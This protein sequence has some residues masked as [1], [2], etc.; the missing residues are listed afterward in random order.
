MHT[1][2]ERSTLLCTHT[3]RS[4]FLCTHTERSVLLCTMLLNDPI[5]FVSG[6]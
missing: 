4:V 1:A 6:I 5:T 2:T 3:E